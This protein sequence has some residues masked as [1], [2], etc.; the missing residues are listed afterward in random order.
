MV[1][2]F[3]GT[4]LSADGLESGLCLDSLPVPDCRLRIHREC[5]GN[6]SGMYR[7]GFASVF[8]TMQ[9]YD[10]PKALVMGFEVF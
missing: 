9:R 10:M 8:L 5:I 4:G 2:C 7:D 3:V 6:V 1:L